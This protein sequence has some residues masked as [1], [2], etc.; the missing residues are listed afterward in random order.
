MSIR[1]FEGAQ[2]RVAELQARIDQ[3]KN[4]PE[5]ST[6]E[7][8]AQTPDSKFRATLDGLINEPNGNLALDPVALGFMQAPGSIGKSQILAMVKSAA[9]KYGLDPK[10]FEALVQ[11]ESGFDP[12]AVSSAGA[13]GLA[14]LM[15]RTAASLG[16]TDPFDPV[17][18]L[19]GG[20]KYLSQMIKQFDGDLRLALAAYNAGPGAVTRSGGIPPFKETQDY[21]RK[22]LDRMGGG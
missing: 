5:P 19:E 21:V 20:A 17:Q 14:Q 12:K 15:P 7:Y 3:L 18:N 1:G 9:D 16:V 13:Q 22:I 8:A 4:K 11:Q 10:L 6:G 2:S